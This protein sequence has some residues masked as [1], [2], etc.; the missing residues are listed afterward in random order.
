MVTVILMA[1]QLL[2]ASGLIQRTS[3]NR[4][5]FW[6]VDARVAP[7]S[8]AR[9]AKTASVT[10]GPEIPQILTTFSNSAVCRG[11]G[12]KAITPGCSSHSWMIEK[13]SPTVLGCDQILGLV[14]IRRN[15]HIATHGKPMDSP[16]A[17]NDS[18][19]A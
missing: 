15:A 17:N 10:C 5:K 3:G 2:P 11:P 4:R 9:A 1:A 12:L 13:A 18:S 8:R 6:S 14:L 7:C 16:P 19:Q